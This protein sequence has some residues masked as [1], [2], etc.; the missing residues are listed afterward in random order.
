MTATRDWF[1]EYLEGGARKITRISLLTLKC[2]NLAALLFWILSV[3]YRS[4]KGHINDVEKYNY[5]RI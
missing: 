1:G 2:R 4:F 5:L 3:F